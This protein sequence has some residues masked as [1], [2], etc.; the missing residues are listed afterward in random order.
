MIQVFVIGDPHFNHSNLLTSENRPF[1]SIEE[2]NKAL[3]K[4]WNNTV[5]KFDHVNVLGDFAFGECKFIL[6]QLKGIKILVMGNHDRRKSPNYWL[7]QGFNEVVRYPIIY[8]SK[9][10]HLYNNKFIFSHEPIEG[11]IGYFKNVCAHR[12]SKGISDANHL[13]VSVEL[14]DYKPVNLTLVDKYFSE[15][16]G[17]AL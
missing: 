10:S 2:M 3:I 15:C 9:S 8:Q 16:K 14:T 5:G 7:K 4:N 11:D 13:F 12:H 17:D 1:C 6:Q